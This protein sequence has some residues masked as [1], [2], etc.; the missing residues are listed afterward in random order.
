MKSKSEDEMYNKLL[1]ELRL[2]LRLLGVK[3]KHKIYEYG[4]LLN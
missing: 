2:V 4:F 3:I 1:G